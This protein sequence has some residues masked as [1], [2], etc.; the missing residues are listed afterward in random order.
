VDVDGE[1]YN[2]SAGDVLTIQS[3][4]LGSRK[5]VHLT[6][7]LSRWDVEILPFPKAWLHVRINPKK[8]R[9]SSHIPHVEQTGSGSPSVDGFS[10]GIVVRVVL[11]VPEKLRWIFF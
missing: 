4:C 9:K 8:R 5:T 10:V 6:G 1:L 2:G 7:Q 11:L 3:K